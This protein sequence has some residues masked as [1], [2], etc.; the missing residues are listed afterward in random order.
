MEI[1]IYSLFHFF[2]V[3]GLLFMWR[4]FDKE[5]DYKKYAKI[6][7]F[8]GTLGAIFYDFV[9]AVMFRFWSYYSTNP[10][11]YLTLTFFTYV[12]AAPLFIEVYGFLNEKFARVKLNFSLK[13]S[14]NLSIFLLILT[15]ILGVLISLLKLNGDLDTNWM[16]FIGSFLCFVIFLDQMLVLLKKAKGPFTQFL[17][18]YIFAPFVIFTSGIL[19]GSLWELLNVNLPLWHS[20]NLPK[21]IVFG[22]SLVVIVFWGTLVYGYWVLTQIFFE[23]TSE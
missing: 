7:I 21:P 3:L 19:C 10:L 2:F 20:N 22:V 17:N 8:V 1:Y 12:V 15:G 11:E 5:Y 16:F 6:T 14:N 23:T 4:L 13:L 18:G 9:G